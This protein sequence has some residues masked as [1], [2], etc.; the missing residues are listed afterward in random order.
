MSAEKFVLRSRA[1]WGMLLPGLALIFNQTGLGQEA[2]GQVS[3]FVEGLLGA[4]GAIFWLWHFIKPDARTPTLRRNVGVLSIVFLVL[5]GLALPVM[6]G[7]V[8]LG[9]K[10][11]SMELQFYEVDGQALIALKAA[12]TALEEMGVEFMSSTLRQS[13]LTAIRSLRPIREETRAWVDACGDAAGCDLNEKIR[14]G[15]DSMISLTGLVTRIVLEFKAEG[16]SSQL[17][18][19]M[20]YAVEVTDGV[21][22]VREGGDNG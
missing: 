5:V 10:D 9:E 12:R 17:E 6:P 2:F 13:L 8:S 20:G 7:C 22:A 16:S 3:T 4:A 1:L 21:W 11:T 19:P 18:G 14:L 15:I